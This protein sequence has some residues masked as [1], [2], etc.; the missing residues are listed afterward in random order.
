MEVTSLSF[1]D[2]MEEAMKSTILS[3]KTDL[4][5]VIVSRRLEV[6]SEFI[7]R[8]IDFNSSTLID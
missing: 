4:L 8:M 3:I 1:P 5:P 7:W 2:L 6:E